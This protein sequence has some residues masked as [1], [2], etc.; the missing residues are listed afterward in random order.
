[1]I[2]KVHVDGAPSYEI[3]DE[4]WPDSLAGAST[5]NATYC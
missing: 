2:L 3:G 1:M 4:I 5:W